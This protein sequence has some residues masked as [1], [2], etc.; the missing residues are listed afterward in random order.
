[1]EIPLIELVVF[2]LYPSAQLTSLNTA[3]VTRIG[4]TGNMAGKALI[5]VN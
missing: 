2:A 3:I 5:H 1:M 4:D